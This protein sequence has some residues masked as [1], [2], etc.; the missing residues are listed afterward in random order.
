MFSPQTP[1]AMSSTDAFRR[2][3]KFGLAWILQCV[4]F[5]V[6]AADALAHDAIAYYNSTM[7]AL[8]GHF[9]YFPRLDMQWKWWF[10]F[11]FLIVVLLFALTRLAYRNSE[12]VRRLALLLSLVGLLMALAQIAATI[13]GGTVPSVNFDG[14][15]PGFYSSPL[16]LFSSLY[17]FW[18]V[19]RLPE[20]V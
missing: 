5:A 20:S 15:S 13:H 1:W 9:P 11:P 8:Y 6:Q 2:T 14:V 4:A 18:M 12:P 17:L 19:R 7:L 10:L 16:L 3:S